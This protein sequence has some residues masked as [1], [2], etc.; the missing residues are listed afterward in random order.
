M[1]RIALLA[2]VAGC[3]SSR[4]GGESSS[5]P[6]DRSVEIGLQDDVKKLAGCTKVSGIIIRTGATID[7][8]PLAALEEISGDLSI[9]PTVGLD[10]AVFNGLVNVGG[11]IRVANNG[12]LRG[13]YFPRLEQSG[14][15]EIEANAVM[16]T[17]S[18]PRLTKVQGAFVIA[19]NGSLEM[20][21]APTLANV[22]K[23]L[24]IAGH[25]KLNLLE[26]SRLTTA[27]AVRIENNPK[28][29]VEVVEQLTSKS[30]LTKQET[31]PAP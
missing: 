13:V 29:S 30:S 2:L 24:V 9:G 16:T 7:V 25:G 18:L 17:I 26:M 8:S 19:D 15:V 11:T 31:P 1:M 6:M 3:F 27:L 5:C 23:E 12:S 14:R 22:G 20:I 21:N 10:E 4:G 28:L